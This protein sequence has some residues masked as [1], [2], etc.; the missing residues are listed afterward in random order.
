MSEE[1]IERAIVIRMF[2][3]AAEDVLFYPRAS[4]LGCCAALSLNAPKHAKDNGSHYDACLKEL[5]VYAPTY[6]ECREACKDPFAEHGHPP[7]KQMPAL[8]TYWWR[9]NTLYLSYTQQTSRMNHVE[10]HAFK[11]K[12]VR[13]CQEERCLFLLFIACAMEGEET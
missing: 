5:E 12:I 10:L 1:H 9:P 8:D 13:Q 3:S 6:A 2:R 7:E 4:M 11:A